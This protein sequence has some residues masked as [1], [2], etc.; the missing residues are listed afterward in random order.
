MEEAMTQDERQ[1]LFSKLLNMTVED[2]ANLIR[3]LELEQERQRQA[4]VD[5]AQGKLLE[6]IMK[7]YDKYIEEVASVVPTN[8]RSIL[9]VLPYEDDEGKHPATISLNYLKRL[10]TSNANGGT[11]ASP[12]KVKLQTG[13]LIT[14]VEFITKEC[15][16]PKETTFKAGSAIR[17]LRETKDGQALLA[18]KG[19]TIA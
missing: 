15:G 14:G 8:Y 16:K 12:G 1:D 11:H 2:R 10:R 9:V 7:S 18:Q 13:Q 5:K 6:A 3:E 4:K 17:W 19:A